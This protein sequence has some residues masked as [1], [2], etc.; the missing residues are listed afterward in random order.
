MTDTWFDNCSEYL[1]SLCLKSIFIKS[2]QAELSAL[3]TDN[4]RVGCNFSVRK[5]GSGVCGCLWFGKHGGT[6]GCNIA[7]TASFVQFLFYDS[8]PIPHFTK[9]GCPI[10]YNQPPHSPL[11]FSLQIH[12]PRILKRVEMHEPTRK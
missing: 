9:S 6:P 8:V 2:F 10:N 5:R 3:N 12:F 4:I 7:V 1:R 11:Q